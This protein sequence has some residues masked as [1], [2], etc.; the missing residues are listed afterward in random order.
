MNVFLFMETREAPIQYLYQVRVLIWQFLS[1]SEINEAGDHV[2]HENCQLCRMGFELGRE[3][4]TLQR[5][6]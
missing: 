5:D 1:A 3:N 6:Q 2:C 4:H